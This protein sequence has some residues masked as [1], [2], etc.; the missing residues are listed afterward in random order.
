MSAQN[1]KSNLNVAINICLEQEHGHEHDVEL[2]VEIVIET[3][4]T[5]IMNSHM[6]GGVDKDNFGH[7]WINTKFWPKLQLKFRESHCV[8]MKFKKT[9]LVQI[10]TWF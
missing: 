10:W 1:L 6:N 9:K 2:K 4:Y 8:E 3:K 5:K 7:V